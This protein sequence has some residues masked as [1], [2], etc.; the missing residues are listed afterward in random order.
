MANC[1]WIQTHFGELLRDHPDQWIAVDQ[2]RVLA[3]GRN[4][5]QVA[6]EAELAWASPHITHYFVASALT[7]L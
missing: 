2:G 3:A 6:D 1:D 5:G 7:L 4:L